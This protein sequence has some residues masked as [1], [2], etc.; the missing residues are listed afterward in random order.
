MSQANIMPDPAAFNLTSFA[1]LLFRRAP[2]IG[3]DHETYDAFHAALIQSLGPATPYACVIA[4]NLVALE[5]ELLQHRKMRD[6][7]LRRF[8]VEVIAAAFVAAQKETQKSKFNAKAAQT[9]GKKLA[10]RATSP[11]AQI[12]HAAQAEIT[13]LGMDPVQVMSEA[14][15]TSNMGVT[16]HDLAIRELEKRRREVKRDF[17]AV[18]KHH[19]PAAAVIDVNADV[20]ARVEAPP[21][22]PRKTRNWV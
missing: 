19:P 12:R 8:T 14:Y 9:A 7:G 13:A 21:A 11:D 10:Q 18:Q 16:H 20:A 15:Q 3:E 2:L 5:W 1:D 4:E 22:K 6:A 17:D